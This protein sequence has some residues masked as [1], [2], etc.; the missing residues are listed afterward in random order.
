MFKGS[1]TLAR[2]VNQKTLYLHSGND[3]SAHAPRHPQPQPAETHCR[4]IHE[5]G[6]CLHIDSSSATSLSDAYRSISFFQQ[7]TVEVP[8]R[9]YGLWSTC[10]TGVNEC[11]EEMMLFWSRCELPFPASLQSV[12]S[13]ARQD[14]T[15]GSTCAKRL[16]PGD[17]E[18]WQARNRVG[19]LKARRS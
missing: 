2:L 16:L 5:L 7:L 17:R 3:A 19:R 8:F 15:A 18:N 4:S 10:C 13:K 14:A 9:T 12:Y 6:T 11:S 1:L